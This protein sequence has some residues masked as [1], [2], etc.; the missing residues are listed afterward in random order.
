V[1][2]TASRSRAATYA[3]TTILGTSMLAGVAGLAGPSPSVAGTP[4]ELAAAAKPAGTVMLK[5]KDVVPSALSSKAVVKIRLSKKPAKGVVKVKAGKHVLAR[6]VAPTSK[7]FRVKVDIAGLKAGQHHL[8]AVYRVRSQGIRIVSPLVAVT[9]LNGCAPLPSACGYPDATNTGPRPGTVL[10]S[11]PDQITSGPGWKYDTRGWIAAVGDGAAI[12]AVRCL[13]GV[14]VEADNV[15][16]SDSE[17]VVAGET[18]GIALRHTTNATIRNNTIRGPVV[19]GPERLM[20]GIKDIYVDSEGLQVLANDIS[21]TSTGVQVE[22]G[23]VADNYIHDLGFTDG[24]HTNGTTSNGGSSPLTLS[25]NTVF[26]QW[27]QTDA[28][29]LFQDF[30]VQRNR[31]ITNNLI[32]G[33]GY[34]LYAGADPDKMSTASNIVVTNNRFSRLF[35][36]KGGYYGPATAYVEGN[37]N[38]WSGNVWDDTGATLKW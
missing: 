16:I 2:R 30:G 26:N 38:Q 34:T 37:G 5:V 24:D 36:P 14:S 20:V 29:S 19:K 13:C 35:F 18:F 12:T 3:A 8:R 21:A 10:R 25:H 6:T 11:V 33:G 27:G 22:S 15:T 17:F 31:V 28:I 1:V 23:L 9:S 7:K 32:A 4:T